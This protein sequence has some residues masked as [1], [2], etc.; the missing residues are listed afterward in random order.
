MI[1]E[2][3]GINLARIYTGEEAFKEFKSSLLRGNSMLT[4][5]MK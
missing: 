3:I 2:E 5:I 4:M 1:A